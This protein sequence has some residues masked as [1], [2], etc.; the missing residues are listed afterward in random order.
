MITTVLAVLIASA[1]GSPLSHED[2]YLGNLL[3]L[4]STVALAIGAVVVW[5]LPWHWVLRLA[6][7]LALAAVL[8]VRSGYF[9]GGDL[10]WHLIR[11]TAYYVIQSIVLSA[12]LGLGPVLPESKA[13]AA[14]MSTQ[15][16]RRA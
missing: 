16:L 13:T 11:D 5:S 1:G 9:A 10:G 8:G 12:W 4:G 15:Q 14:A 3:W 6:S 2:S 7:V